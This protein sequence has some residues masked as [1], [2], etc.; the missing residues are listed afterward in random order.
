MTDLEK[1]KFDGLCRAE[2][3]SGASS[4]A[5]GIGT[6]AEKRLHRI[7]KRFVTED[8]SCFEISVGPYVAD[9]LEGD[10]ITEI[11]TGTLRPLLPKLRYYLD[12]TD[13]DLTVIHPIITDTLLI[14][15]DRETGEVLR[16][17]LSSLHGG[18]CDIL[19]ELFWIRDLFPRERLKIKVLLIRAEEYRYSERM[20]YRREGAFDSELYP[21]EL[22]D[23]VELCSP[24]DLVRFLPPDKDSFC[25]SEYAAYIKRKG[26]AVYSSLNFLCAAGL[27][28]RSSD[29]KRY[30]YTKL[31]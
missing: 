23:T 19:P 1:K 27:L 24:D 5:S 9:V 10:R 3:V 18:P 25:A 14:R 21:I 31:I 29:G 4:S 11:Q 12:N 26:R 22:V 28:E 15:V 13:L 20:R 2:T 7:I 6:Y 8:E 17:R 30:I 16:R